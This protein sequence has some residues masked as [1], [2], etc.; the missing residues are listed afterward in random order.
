MQKPQKITFG[1]MRESVVRFS[2]SKVFDSLAAGYLFSIVHLLEFE[3]WPRILF[4]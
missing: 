2:L 4:K 1:E 3:N